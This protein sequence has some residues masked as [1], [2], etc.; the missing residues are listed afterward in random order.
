MCLQTVF[1]IASLGLKIAEGVQANAAAKSEAAYAHAG[2]P[3]GIN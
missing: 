2:P 1:T 3:R